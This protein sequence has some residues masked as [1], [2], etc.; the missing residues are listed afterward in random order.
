MQKCSK[1]PE[2]HLEMCSYS[3][4]HLL[5]MKSELLCWA[6]VSFSW[7]FPYVCQNVSMSVSCVHCSQMV[8][9]SLMGKCCKAWWWWWLLLL[10]VASSF[11]ASVVEIEHNVI[12]F[13]MNLG[14]MFLLACRKIMHLQNLCSL[15][16]SWRHQIQFSTLQLNKYHCAL[17][18]WHPLQ[19]IGT[20]DVSSCWSM[21]WE[22]AS[23]YFPKEASLLYVVFLPVECVWLTIRIIF[24][25]LC[26]AWNSM[27]IKAGCGPGVAVLGA[28]WFSAL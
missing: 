15:H 24:S 23:S 17:W 4:E 10:L 12:N 16:N 26:C 3:V 25:L 19:N 21:G 1:Y 9:K 18:L 2:F 27:N 14:K 5:L 28:T 22:L 6:V 8:Q 13:L 7:A 11:A 20:S